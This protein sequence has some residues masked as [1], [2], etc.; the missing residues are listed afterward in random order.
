MRN[1]KLQHPTPILLRQ[2]HYGGQGET[3]NLKLQSSGSLAVS[4]QFEH[5]G[6]LT[7]ALSPRRGSPFR[8]RWK[9][10]QTV[11]FGCA[12]KCSPS[13]GEGRG[14]G[15]GRVQLHPYGLPQARFKNGARS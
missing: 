15:K 5:R 8:P 13:R 10:H 7:P 14:E 12:T 9:P 11:T 3:P 1:S 4:I 6:P 2:K